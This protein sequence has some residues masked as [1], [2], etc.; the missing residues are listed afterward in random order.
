MELKYHWLCR[1]VI[2]AIV[3]VCVRC[4]SAE[5]SVR[6]L[7]RCLCVS[8]AT[9]KRLEPIS[10]TLHAVVVSRPSRRVHWTCRSLNIELHIRYIAI[11]FHRV[12]RPYAKP[13]EKP[14]KPA[15][16]QSQT[17]KVYS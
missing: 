8:H 1:R 10:F 12:K 15:D 4:L 13:R 16:S 5:G 9:R 3:V 14:L 6:P 17:I 11:L 2:N 7:D